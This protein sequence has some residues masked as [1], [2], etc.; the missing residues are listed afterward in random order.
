M[1]DKYF[2]A[3]IIDKGLK[4]DEYTNLDWESFMF[5]ICNIT[6]PNRRFDVLRLDT[7]WKVLDLKNIAR[8]KETEDVRDLAWELFKFIE[9]L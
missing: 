1:Y 8:L 2:N 3:K 6:N 7:I 9:N 5:R 4:S